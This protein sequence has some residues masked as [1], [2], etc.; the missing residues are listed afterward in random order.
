MR[1]RHEQD[2]V[3]ALLALA[4]LIGAI[5]LGLF[6]ALLHWA[7][8]PGR[9]PQEPPSA[10]RERPVLLLLERLADR[11][12]GLGPAA[13]FWGPAMAG[14]LIGILWSLMAR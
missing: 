6:S 13:R 4:P 10:A 1:R 14:L 11:V 7:R 5:A 2:L 8:R 3:F 12:A 9:P